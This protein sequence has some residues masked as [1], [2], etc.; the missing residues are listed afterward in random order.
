M[1]FVLQRFQIHN[2]IH[3]ATLAFLKPALNAGQSTVHFASSFKDHTINFWKAFKEER[4]SQDRIANLESKL[5]QYHEVLKE[6]ERLLDLLD[7][8]KSLTRKSIAARVIGWD[9]SPWR[10]TLLLDKG[11]EAGLEKDM[12]VVVGQGLV[13]RIFEVG[14]STARVLLLTDPD[15]RVSAVASE[16]RAQGVVEGNGKPDL[17]M[18]YLHLD[19]GVKVGE[20]V[21]TSGIGP[22]FPKGIRIGKIIRIGKDDDGLHL[23]AEIEPF[24]N[25]TKLEEVLCLSLSAQN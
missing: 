23:A 11:L 4:D 12:A 2:E 25:F 15:A 18:V 16:S 8:K 13:G 14:E 19:S 5:L 20:E 3:G 17:K 7:F 9:A 22:V 6:N 1:L 21:L 24:V 10:R